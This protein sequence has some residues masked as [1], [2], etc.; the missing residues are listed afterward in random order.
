MRSRSEDL[1]SRG[2]PYARATSRF[3]R[4]LHGHVRNAVRRLQLIVNVR[5]RSD[6]GTSARSRWRTI[7]RHLATGGTG[8]VTISTARDC[9]WSIAA[10]A[11]WVS[12]VGDHS[13]QGDG[14][15][16]YSVAANTVPTSRLGSIVVGSEGTTQP[17][18]RALPLRSQPFQRFNRPNGWPAHRRRHDDERLSVGRDERLGVDRR[19]L[20][21]IRQCHRK[22]WAD[23]FRKHRPGA[24]RIGENGGNNFSVTRGCGCRRR[25][26]LPP[27]HRNLRRRLLATLP[28]ATGAVQGTVSGLSGRCSRRS[29]MRRPAGRRQPQPP[30]RKVTIYRTAIAWRSRER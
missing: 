18:R 20:G 4:S 27:L 11:P 12:I 21:A 10:D 29:F 17:G 3:Q 2:E 13:G 23:G 22:S 25:L 5:R 24:R 14:V 6:V 8:S 16:T 7:R 28:A 9:T 19:V 1:D 15:V 30:A 26:R